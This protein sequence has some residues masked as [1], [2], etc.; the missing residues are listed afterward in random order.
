MFPNPSTGT[1]NIESMG[2]DGETLISV[3]N[4]NGIEVYQETVHLTAA[5]SSHELNL[6]TLGKGLY[7]IRFTGQDVHHAGKI[8]IW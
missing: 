5:G 7:F 1:F 2:V 3:L 4:I 8:I 6:T